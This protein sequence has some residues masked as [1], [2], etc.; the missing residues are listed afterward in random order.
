MNYECGDCGKSD[1][2]SIL[3]M[4]RCDCDRVDKHGRTK[5]A[6]GA[7]S[8]DKSQQTLSSTYSSSSS[9]TG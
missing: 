1:H 7:H 8:S 3:A 2:T 4:M 5:H 9:T 6:Y